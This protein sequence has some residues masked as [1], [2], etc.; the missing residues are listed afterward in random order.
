[1]TIMDIMVQI[2]KTVK[3]D[4]YGRVTLPAKLAELL[5]L[6][7]GEDEVSWHV[8]GGQVIL[9]KETVL[10][11]GHDFEGDEIRGRLTEYEEEHC[12]DFTDEVEMSEEEREARARAEYEKAKKARAELR[13]K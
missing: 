6:I 8:V 1:M 5:D 12:H 3:Y 7:K 11:N 9:K 10:Y 2:G 13:K 4:D